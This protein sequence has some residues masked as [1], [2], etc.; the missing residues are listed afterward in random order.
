MLSNIRPGRERDL[1]RRGFFS[2]SLAAAGFAAI[3][4]PGGA[5]AQ[6]VGVRARDLPYLTIK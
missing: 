1:S 3:S 5:A 2:S 4:D 6:S